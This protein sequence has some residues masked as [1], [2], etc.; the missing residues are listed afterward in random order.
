MK[1]MMTF[2]FLLLPATLIAATPPYKTNDPATDEDFRVIFDAMSTHQHDNDGT[3]RLDTVVIPPRSAIRGTITSKTVG[4]VFF[5][6]T[7]FVTC[8]ST[9]AAS[10]TAWVIQSSTATVCPH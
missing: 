8:I 7:S 9:A 10:T 5:D 4:Q 1:M 2:L 6:T 3:M